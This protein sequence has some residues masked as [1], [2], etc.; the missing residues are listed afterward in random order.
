[1]RW[2]RKE[3]KGERECVR[4]EGVEP[5]SH[6]VRASYST[7]KLMAQGKGSGL[8]RSPIAIR[9]ALDLDDFIAPEMS[10]GIL[11]LALGHTFGNLV[12]DGFPNLR[13]GRR[14]GSQSTDDDVM[15][16]FVSRGILCLNF[17]TLVD[18]LVQ[19]GEDFL[20]VIAEVGQS[21]LDGF[22]SGFLHTGY[23]FW[24]VRYPSSFV[25]PLEQ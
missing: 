8:H 14:S 18:F 6:W 5:S 17:G 12:L 24:F 19:F 2:A 10:Q 13:N 25:F 23:P 3:R 1:M 15:D 4:H 9:L 16:G 7:I 21:G 20:I 22:K 11:N